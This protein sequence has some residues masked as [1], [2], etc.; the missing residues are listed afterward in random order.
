M[1]KLGRV[2]GSYSWTGLGP[3][4]RPGP[5]NYKL[6]KGAYNVYHFTLGSN[7]PKINKNQIR[8]FLFLL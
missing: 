2:L 7:P 4:K 3:T 6:E 5:M 1:R 8:Y